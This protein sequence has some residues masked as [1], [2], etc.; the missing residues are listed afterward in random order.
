MR[1]HIKIITRYSLMILAVVL[2]FS[3]A[4]WAFGLQQSRQKALQDMSFVCANLTSR[5][6]SEISSMEFATDFFLSNTDALSSVF[7]LATSRRVTTAE[8]GHSIVAKQ[9]LQTLM[10]TYFVDRGYYRFNYF[11]PRGDY[12]TSDFRRKTLPDG[13]FRMEDADWSAPADALTRGFVILPPHPDPWPLAGGG[14]VFSV[15]RRIQG[16]ANMGYLEVQME[17]SLLDDIFGLPDQPGLSSLVVN[18]GGEILYSP[19]AADRDTELVQRVLAQLPV[20]DGADSTRVLSAE[21]ELMVCS[22]SAY[23]GYYVVL[24]QPESAITGSM[25]SITVLLVAIALAVTAI[26][27]VFISVT[28]RR[29]TGPIRQLRDQIN[30]ADL[31]NLD[32]DLLLPTG[33]DEIESLQ[34]A[35]TSLLERLQD[36]IER[37]A[38][39]SSLQILAHFDSLQAQVNPHF[40]YNVLNVVS[41]RGVLH[42]DETICNI[43]DSLAAMLRYSTDTNHRYATIRQEIDYLNSYLYLLHTRYLDQLECVIEVDPAIEGQSLPKIV[44]QQIVEN[45]VNHGFQNSTGRMRVL[46]EGFCRGD[47]W[48]IRITDN[49]QGFAP[50]ILEN[51]RA[52]MA[53]Q[54]ETAL[55]PHSPDGMEIGGMGLL[56]TYLRLLLVFRETLHFT[57]DNNGDGG[58]VVEIGSVLQRDTKP[59]NSEEEPDCSRSL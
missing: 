36:A 18:A 4:F 30:R 57:I 47:R 59:Q 33:N 25:G 37:E 52:E 51:L 42:E 6:E 48:Y 23:T 58:A 49:G 53:R 16:N 19:G 28:A 32:T 26:S 34:M 22:Y 27:L 2:V 55:R 1:F 8:Q 29:L 54:R 31:E 41:H 44:L 3:L 50:D 7:I 20:D 14:M 38:R 39:L 12:I 9:T 21:G 43:C 45:S 10:Y 5:L 46:L 11:N 13:E 40:L 17:A 15:L 24:I 35:Y 56:N